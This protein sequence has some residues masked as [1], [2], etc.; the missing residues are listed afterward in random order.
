MM[1]MVS[2]LLVGVAGLLGVLVAL[3]LWMVPQ[4]VAIQLGVEPI[5]PFGL[6]TIRADVAGFFAG[7][8][9]LSLFAAIRNRAVLLTAPLILVGL[10]L[11]GRLITAGTSG[12]T[13]EMIP[14]MAIEAGL[15]A[16]LALGRHQLAR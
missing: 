16:V 8:G 1:Q 14:P 3:R 5:G 2:R 13:N 10:A 6:A 4:E 7:A 12:I 15:L 11:T 9:V